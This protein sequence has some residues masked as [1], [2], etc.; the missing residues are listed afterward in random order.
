[1]IGKIA[2]LLRQ[3]RVLPVRKAE[4]ALFETARHKRERPSFSHS[5]RNGDQ[6]STL[7]PRR[8]MLI[9]TILRTLP[10]D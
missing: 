9:E 10:N 5:W 2:T 1:M 8:C 6:T 7:R 3:L 4:Q